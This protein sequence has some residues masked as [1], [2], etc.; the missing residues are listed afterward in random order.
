MNGVRSGVLCGVRIAVRGLRGRH[1]HVVAV[2]T[3]WELR[4]EHD[5]PRLPT[6]VYRRRLDALRALRTAEVTALDLE[7][8]GARP[9]R[10]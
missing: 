4:H 3:S 9:G 1:D 2:T 6:G 8:A 10:R 7:M 5:P